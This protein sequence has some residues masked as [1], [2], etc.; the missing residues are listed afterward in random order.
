MSPSCSLCSLLLLLGGSLALL[1]KIHQDCI[2]GTVGQS[3]LLPVSYSLDSVPDS[4]VS[5]DWRF[6]NCSDKMVT[7]QLQDCSLGAAGAPNSCSTNCFTHATSRGRAQ[8]FPRNG[9]L[10]LRDLQLRDSGIY[11]VTFRP[12][13]RTWNI[14]LAVHEQRVPPARPGAK[15]GHIHYS[16]IGICSS[17]PLLLLVLLFCC[18]WRCGTARQQKRII[19]EQQVSGREEPHMESVLVRDMTTVY[20][21]VGDSFEQPQQSP[22][23]MVMYKSVMSPGPTGPDEGLYHLQV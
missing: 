14:T 19:I 13:Q 16:I 21:R 15:Q 9:S 10:L 20:A 12:W 22:A 2:D 8:L 11:F 7:C 17:V 23:Q 6:S 18:L 1:V 5:V 3:V 4:P